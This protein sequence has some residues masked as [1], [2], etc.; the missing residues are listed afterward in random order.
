MQRHFMITALLAAT[1]FLYTATTDPAHAA[2]PELDAV[3]KVQAKYFQAGETSGVVTLVS[4]HGKIVHLAAVGQAD[5]EKNSPLSAD[6]VF[7]IASMTKPIT[8]TAFMTLVDEGKVSIDD[9]VEKYLP[10][11]ADAKVKAIVQKDKDGNE[12]VI[13]PSEK[14]RGLL[15]RHLLTHTSGLG[16]DQNCTVSLEATANDLARREFDFQPGAQW[17]YGPSLNVIG[18]IIEVVSGKSYEEFVSERILKPLA[19]N[20]TTFHPTAK[21][22]ARVPTLYSR[23]ADGPLTPASRPFAT[24]S[25]DEVPSPSGGLFS[26]AADLQR[27]Y[28]AILNGGELDGVRIGSA[29]SV[30]KMTTIQTADDIVTGFTPGNGWG[31]GWCVVRDPQGV[32]EHLSPGSFGH[33]GY[34]GTQGVVDPVKKRVYVLLYQRLGLPNSDAA[35]LRKDFYAAADEA[36]SLQK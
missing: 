29:D 25:P 17:Q 22:L 5:L 12:V 19:M 9:P 35:D 11:F 3:T 30:K 16:G 21:Q 18:R 10:A 2:E 28:Q 27:F 13:Q 7:A 20:D 15:I 6:A 31:L 24:G 32:T 34:Y 4:D 33:G 1:S 36:L 26:T 8:A 23:I 14:V